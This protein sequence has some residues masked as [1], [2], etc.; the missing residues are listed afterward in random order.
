MLFWISTIV[1]VLVA[2]GFLAQVAAILLWVERKQ[3]AM[4][5]NRIGPNRATIKIGNFEIRAAGLVHSIADGIKMV[6]KADWEPSGGDHLLYRLAP[7][8]AIVPA[9]CLCA[10]I[11]FAPTLYVDHARDLYD[12]AWATDVATAARSIPM[13]IANLDV[14]VLFV[15]AVAGAG[16]IGAALAGWSSDNKFSLM[17]GLRAASQMV[18][19][20]VAMGISLVGSMMIFQ[21]VRLDEMVTWQTQHCWG[22]F[23]QPVAFVLFVTAA[24]AE[25]KR[26]PFDTPEGESELVAGYFTEYAGLKMAMFASGEFVEVCV[27]SALITT[28][29]LGGWQFPF[30]QLTGLEFHYLGLNVS[31]H[32]AHFIVVLVGFI[33][34]SLKCVFLIFMQLQVRWTLP[35]FRYDQIMRLGWQM[36]LPA[37]LL[38]VLVTGTVL[39]FLNGPTH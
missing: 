12:P 18:S 39:L 2:V 11:P 32:W 13:Q 35:R 1:K 30:V 8:I 22:I 23:V 31:W 16:V 34:F 24:I 29:F 15:F 3:S 10:V 27:S 7:I 20:E 6:W 5:Q 25:T 37:A 4:M 36:L 33:T 19:Y 38:N 17:G 9:L 28:I 21:T 14:G 26:V